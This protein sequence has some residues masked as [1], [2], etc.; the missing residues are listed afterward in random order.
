MYYIRIISFFLFFKK[1]NLVSII[2]L[3]KIKSNK[4]ILKLKK[5]ELISIF[6]FR[7]TGGGGIPLIVQNIILF[8]SNVSLK[9]FF[10]GTLSGIFPGNLLLSILGIGI[11]EALKIFII[12]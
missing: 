9:N 12:S 2:N 1:S 8:Y 4:I 6:L 5:N 11:F 7:I 3:K 10:I